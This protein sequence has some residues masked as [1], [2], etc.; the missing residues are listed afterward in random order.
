[1][2]FVIENSPKNITPLPWSNVLAG[3]RMGA[4][5]TESGGGY[6]WCGNAR[7]LRITPWSNDALFDTSGEFLILFDIERE[8]RLSLFARIRQQLC[9][10]VAWVWVQ[11]F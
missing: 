6:T 8:S 3:K 2:E 4:L 10:R 5:V 9:K 1:M 7:M 11:P